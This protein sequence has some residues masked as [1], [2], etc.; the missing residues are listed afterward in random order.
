MGR[1]AKQRRQSHGSAWHWI[2]TDC[3]Y[4]TL[5]CTKKRVANFDEQGERSADEQFPAFDTVSGAFM[6][7][8]QTAIIN[9]ESVLSCRA[10]VA[11][12]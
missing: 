6:E 5:P 10:G 3:W 7:R 12:G 9:R 4:Y 11:L 8:R 2:Q 1:K